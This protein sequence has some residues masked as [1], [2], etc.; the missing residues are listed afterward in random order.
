MERSVKSYLT[1]AISKDLVECLS[2]MA[3]ERPPNPHVWM[4]QR[5]L[6]RGQDA[7]SY[8]VVRREREKERDKAAVAKDIESGHY[9]R[10]YHKAAEEYKAPAEYT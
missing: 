3:V 9:G 7:G 5:L 4:A 10:P 2:I 1:G 8:L 6:E